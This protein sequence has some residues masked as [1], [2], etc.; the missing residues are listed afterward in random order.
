M[1]IRD[2][3]MAVWFVDKEREIAGEKRWI[4]PDGL[5]QCSMEASSREVLQAVTTVVEG[6][7]EEDV[8]KRQ[9]RGCCPYRKNSPA[10]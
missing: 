9:G 1:C 10:S 4:I 5:L 3:D 8:Y 2:S 7:A 6:V